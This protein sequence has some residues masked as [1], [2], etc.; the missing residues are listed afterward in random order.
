[1]NKI[2][3]FCENTSELRSFDP[4]NISLKDHLIGSAAAIC[5]KASEVKIIIV[6]TKTGNSARE[7][8]RYRL[9]IPII[10][11]CD[12]NM[13][14]RELALSYGVIPLVVNFRNTRYGESG[15]VFEIIKK[16]GWC[17][18]GETALVIHGTNWLEEGSANSLS[19]R[20]KL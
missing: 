4:R 11:V 15:A 18:L 1:M 2:A 5:Q 3:R 19:F 7:L 10:A 12:S 13:T 16:K 14:A 9:G 20:K 8:S 6:F 17:Q